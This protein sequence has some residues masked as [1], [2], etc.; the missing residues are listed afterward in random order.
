MLELPHVVVGAA[1]A[2][3]IGNPALALPLALSSH[4]V[5]D[6]LPHWNPHLN[7]ELKEKGRIGLKTT[8][9]IVVDVIASLAAGFFIA[10]QVLPDVTHFWVVIAASFL[11]VAPDVVEGPHFFLRWRYPFV[12]KLIKFQKSIQNDAPPL[13]GLLTQVL[14]MGAAFWWIF[15]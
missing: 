14:I 10:S 11:A 12:E 15:S 8:M 9:F 2:T 3:K 13:L 4:F 6:V 5:L 7:R 1:I